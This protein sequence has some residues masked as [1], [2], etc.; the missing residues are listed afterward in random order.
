M[1]TNK[2]KKYFFHDLHF[3]LLLN[4]WVRKSPDLPEFNQTHNPAMFS[5]KRETFV[6]QV[7]LPYM[8]PCF[9]VHFFVL[10]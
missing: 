1:V 3:V 9:A 2:S 4:A 5:S 7:L 10:M 6:L 8:T